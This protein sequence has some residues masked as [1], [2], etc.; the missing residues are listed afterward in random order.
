[1][2]DT[3]ESHLTPHG[4]LTAL[5]PGLWQVTGLGPPL[6]RNMAIARLRDG[7]LWLHSVV[8]VD[9]PTLAAIE[10]LG[11]PRVMVVPNP[12]HRRDAAVWKARFPDLAVLAPA[13]ARI[14]G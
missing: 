1:M 12:Y 11:P 9:P 6:V 5:V 2:A 3:W 13:A 7:G 8:A 10:A 4:P 14:R